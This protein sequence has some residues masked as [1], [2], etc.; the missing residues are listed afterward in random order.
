MQHC[1]P[2]VLFRSLLGAICTLAFT[3]CDSE[4]DE[5]SLNTASD[6]ETSE[7]AGTTEPDVSPPVE[8]TAPDDTASGVDPDPT[9]PY[10]EHPGTVT[11]HRLNRAEYNNTVRDLMGDQTGPAATFPADDHAHGYDNVANAL[12]MNPL[13]CEGYDRAAEQ[14]IE[15]ALY[16]PVKELSEPYHFEGEELTGSAGKA[17]ATFWNLWTNGNVPV[18]VEIE[19]AGIYVVSAQHKGGLIASFFITV[20][21]TLG[22]P[23]SSFGSDGTGPLGGLT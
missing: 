16:T 3:A 12:A 14:L 21:N 19:K 9:C 4:N 17:T 23:D 1:A 11:L 2:S 20:M 8:T 10:P 7:E 6:T 13:L 5:P 22:L 15:T 18:T